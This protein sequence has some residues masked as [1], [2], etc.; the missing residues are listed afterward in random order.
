MDK[1]DPAVSH[2]SSHHYHQPGEPRHPCVLG[3][4]KVDVIPPHYLYHPVLPFQ[5]GG[6]LTLPL[7]RTC[8]EE[9]MT[10][11]LLE[12][13]HHCPHSLEE[14]LLRS[15]W[16]TPELFKAVDVGYRVMFM[17]IVK[18]V[19]GRSPIREWKQVRLVKN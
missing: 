1:Q 19:Y 6:K 3:I 17:V 14:H 16:C 9:E 18:N 11:G 5:H 2:W 13:S 12:K 4:A 10:E 8:M 15:T 7:C